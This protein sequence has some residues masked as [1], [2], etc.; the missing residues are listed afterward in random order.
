MPTFLNKG[1]MT[2]DGTNIP[3]MVYAMA[4]REAKRTVS[5]GVTDL[6]DS[7]GGTA[8]TTF[9]IGAQSVALAN[10]ANSGTNLSDTTTSLAALTAVLDAYREIGTKANTIATALGIT[11]VTYSVGGAAADGTVG[12]ISVGVT[13]AA[14]GCQA[15]NINLALTGF[16]NTAYHLSQFINKL[17]VACGVSQL[18]CNATS[19]SGG[20]LTTLPAIT[21]ATGAAADPGVTKAALDAQLVIA[22]N[23]VATLA[24]RL[25][26]MSTDTLGAP[27]IIAG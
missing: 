20:Y 25:N 14:T 9:V 15:T 21:V 24:A 3:A 4:Q 11:N 10:A 22:R 17:A 2:A 1:S 5:A 6:T 8:S 12:A 18:V 23:N 19:P 16:N 7:T 26:A 13:A 27:A